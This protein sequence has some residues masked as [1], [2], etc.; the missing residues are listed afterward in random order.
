MPASFKRRSLRLFLGARKS[1]TIRW[2][3]P[4]TVRVGIY[5]LGRVKAD[6]G[7]EK[8]C[9]KRRRR[10]GQRKGKSRSRVGKTR[11][12][13]P[14]R[15]MKSERTRQAHRATREQSWVERKTTFLIDRQ[16]RY[17]ERVGGGEARSKPVAP[18][19]HGVAAQV[20]RMSSQ[21]QPMSYRKFVLCVSSEL[22]RMDPDL[23][24][25]VLPVSSLTE[26]LSGSN[27]HL[28]TGIPPPPSLDSPARKKTRAR[29]DGVGRILSQCPSCKIPYG[30]LRW[31]GGS[32]IAE[33][34][35]CGKVS[36]VPAPVRQGPL[37][38]AKPRAA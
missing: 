3:G 28:R 38:G 33:C 36:T 15:S 29:K 14:V 10:R 27:V 16:E 2:I 32:P 5:T 12:T 11:R 34:S 4:P 17:N 8:S 26:A 35:K 24:C 18:M 13:D 23:T 7:A 1:R 22:W 19:Y 21:G 20:A 25:S 37:V 31:R 30:P 6:E 9:R